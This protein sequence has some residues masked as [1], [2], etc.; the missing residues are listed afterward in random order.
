MTLALCGA[1][2]AEQRFQNPDEEGGKPKALYLCGPLL[3]S[4][5]RAHEVL[6]QKL[7]REINIREISEEKWLGN[8]DSVP[9]PALDAL[10]KGLRKSHEG[11]DIY[12][13]IYEEAVGNVR[14]YKEGEPMSFGEWVEV[15]KEAFA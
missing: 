3:M 14:K 5:R 13:E 1:V 8:F 11:D 7:G 9:R 6:A 10:L 2:L 4:Q 15:N 12:E